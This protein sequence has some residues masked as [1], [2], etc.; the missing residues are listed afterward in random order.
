MK[1][2]FIS[3]LA[4]GSLM[5]A[6]AASNK[7]A[8]LQSIS[9]AV[10]KASAAKVA[11]EMPKTQTR[12]GQTYDFG[13]CAGIG[14]AIGYPAGS[15]LEA[16]IEIPTF[17]AQSWEGCE[18]TKIYIGYGANGNDTI[19]VFITD[20]LEGYPLYMQEA[21]MKNKALTFDSSGQGRIDQVWNEVVLDKPFKIDGNPFYLGYQ[22]IC[23]GQ[24]RYP[25][26]FDNIYTENE[27]GDILGCP[28]GP[29]GEM[30]YYNMG[31]VLGNVSI[32]FE[33]QGAMTTQYDA[34]ESTLFLDSNL[35]VA[36]GQFDGAFTLLNIGS[37][38]ITDLDVTCTVGGVEAKDVE[39]VLYGE[40][41]I[42]SIPFGVLGYVEITGRPADGVVGLDLPLVIKV[43][44]LI[45][46]NGSG[47]FYAEFNT[48]V[49]VISD[50]FDRN[51]VVEEFTG[52]WCGFCPRGIVG[53]DY[54]REKYGDKGF[55][56]IAVHSDDNMETES[57]YNMLNYFGVNPE[58][59]QLSFPG[60]VMD[61]S[62][63]FD[64]A[65]E[66][67]EAYYEYQ[68]QIPA[69][70][71]IDAVA[72]YD[73]KANAINAS[74]EAEFVFDNDNAAYGIAFVVVENNVGPYYQQNYFSGGAYGPLEG[75]SNNTA[76]V[77]TYY[78][79]VARYISAGFGAE[80]SIPGRVKAH[81]AYPYSVSMPLSEIKASIINER[82]PN[83]KVEDCYVVALLLDLNNGAVINGVQVD[84]SEDAGVEGIIADPTD[85]VYR[86]YN[87]QGIKVMET[88]NAA[89]IDSLNGVYIINGKK[90]LVK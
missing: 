58:T 84:L 4:I 6:S 16:A 60:A 39:V 63:Y 86:V 44:K 55:I 8:N 26:G 41:G 27:Y 83:V 11:K 22:T 49:T 35:L 18:I 74:A 82:N 64:P 5:G 71:K 40:N 38:T 12:A 56:G 10:E 77:R 46:R 75:W 68:S 24:I 65:M 3:L 48:P 62:I 76:R 73:E 13:Y 2:L 50:G 88:T 59:G 33:M 80:G 87:L 42:G 90:V 21:V 34:L 32:R 31:T 85:G 66:T 69:L 70:G 53:M 45:G 37:E 19:N 67:L 52:T 28:D 29:K 81:T 72:Y 23:E 61:R 30:V 25:I 14:N 20:D 1:R 79:M 78:E 89:D 47:D 9:S 51:V 7:P 57:Y 17:M 36:G 54:M 43:N 15:V